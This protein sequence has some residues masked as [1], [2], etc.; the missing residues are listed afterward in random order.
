MFFSDVKSRDKSKGFEIDIFIPSISTGIEYDGFYYHSNQK[1]MQADENKDRLCRENG[2]TLYRIRESGLPI[3]SFAHN[4]IRK[5]FTDD[6]LSRN[7][8]MLLIELQCKPIANVDIDTSRI[9]AQYMTL[10]SENSLSKKAPEVAKNWNY[11]KNFPLKPEN[12]VAGASYRA[13]WTCKSCGAN[14]RASVKYEVAKGGVCIYCSGTKYKHVYQYD[15]DGIYIN[16]FYSITE[17]CE[18]TGV[19][20][21]SIIRVCK[22]V[23][24]TAG[25]YKWS[26]YNQKLL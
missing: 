21:S 13:W 6:E 24:K 26:Y 10:Y 5:E 25:G 22:G 23:Q 3:T 4:I 19:D 14:W 16:D 15:K 7:I 9:L 1:R 11:E 20:S 12:V 18:E 2:I 8:N 17:A